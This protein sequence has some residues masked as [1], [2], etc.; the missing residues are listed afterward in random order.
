M[1]HTPGPSVGLGCGC[2]PSYEGGYGDDGRS[3]RYS[4]DWCPLHKAAPEMLKF[5][6]LVAT[7]F[8]RDGEDARALLARIEGR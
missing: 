3:G 8:G 6:E 7:F 1:S 4:M 5:V 2:E